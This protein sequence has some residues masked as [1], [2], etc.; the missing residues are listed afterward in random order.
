MQAI[1]MVGNAVDGHTFIGP[2]KEGRDAVEYAEHHYANETFW[3]IS[4]T[5]P[6]TS[7][8][9]YKI[10]RRYRENHDSKIILVGMTL[11]KA[12]EWC[13]DLNTSSSTATSSSATKHTEQFG[14]WFDTYEEENFPTH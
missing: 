6:E 8:K 3:I 2:F 4:L 10:V 5:N 12:Q 14:P 7:G 11:E 13:H 1:I 9:T